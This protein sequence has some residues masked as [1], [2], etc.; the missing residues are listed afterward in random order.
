MRLIYVFIS[1]SCQI[2]LLFFS[3]IMKTVL[4][5]GVGR[6]TQTLIKYLTT[7]ATKLNIK[8]VLADQA[9][10]NFIQPYIQQELCTFLPL[11]INDTIRRKNHISNAD[12]IISMLPPKFHY[13]VAKDCIEFKKNLITASYVSEEIAKLDQ[14]A[15]KANILILNEVGLDPG[16]DHI[17]AMD[18]IDRLKEQGASINVFK[19]FCG[20]LIA[21][22]SDDNPWNYKFTWN[23]KNVVLAGSSGASYLKNGSVKTFDYNQVFSNLETISIP[24]YGLFESYANRDSLHYQEKYALSD[25]QTIVRG[26][27][28]KVGFA[29]AWDVFVQLGMT[30][31][32]KKTKLISEKQF[33]SY[34][35]SL[36]DPDIQ[37]KMDYLDLFNRKY[38]IEK[39]SPS[40]YLIKVLQDK[41]A[42][43]QDDIDMIVMQHKFEY[44]QNKQ[45]KKLQ[46]SMVVKGDN[47]IHTAMAKTVG[48]PVFFACK[49]LL[50]DKVNLKGVRIP[51]YKEIYQPILEQLS[52]EGINFVES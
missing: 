17:S 18:V 39:L 48:L 14:D 42:L 25:A 40:D 30:S 15:K 9:S 47:N 23:P 45:S 3:K 46:L 22:E 27:L 36:G 7:N 49:L 12:L 52:L 6:S 13:I 38:N 50:Q 26:T 1:F 20:G 33:N 44:V 8:I 37:S 51:I 10:N 35:E 5:L 21:P 24:N 11:D 19:S 41:W 28:R 29:K 32:S 4:L 34:M 31:E 16:I 43:D 2:K